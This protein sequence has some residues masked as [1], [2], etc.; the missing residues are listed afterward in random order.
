M[1]HIDLE[2]VK[3][4]IDLAYNYELENYSND[5]NGFRLQLDGCANNQ[6]EKKL[7]KMS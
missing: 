6:A 7:I 5:M 4:A 2:K 1:H 3:K